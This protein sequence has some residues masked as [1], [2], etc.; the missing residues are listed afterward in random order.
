MEAVIKYRI[1]FWGSGPWKGLAVRVT[2]FMLL[3]L[4][5]SASAFDLKILHIND[6]H[7]HLQ[8]DSKMELHLGG[9][10]TRVQA[11]GFPRL[12]TL[13][14]KLSA[15]QTNVL[16]LHA[17]DAIT[18]DL[19]YTLFKGE[20][21][22]ALMN[23]ICFDAF[24]LGNHEFD[25]GDSGLARFLDF[26][27]RGDC[28]TAVLGAN[29]V[30]EVGVSPLAKSS[31]TDY[32]RPYVVKKVGGV[33]VGIVGID[34]AQKTKLSSNPDETTVFLDEAQTAQEMIDELERQGIMHIILMTHYQYLNDLALVPR[35]RGVDVVVGGDS[36]TLLGDFQDIELNS[37]GP[38]PTVIKDAQGDTV[39][40]VQAW[41]YS[42]IVGELNVRFADDGTVVSCSGTPHLP[43][44]DSFR[45]T[46]ADDAWVELEGAERDGVETAI[47]GKPELSIVEEDVNTAALLASFS[48]EVN[49]LKNQVIGNAKDRLC[50]ERIPG[51][52]KS[53][54][55]D[56]SE[57]AAHG[58]DIATL[59]AHVFR[60]ASKTS[61]IAI[62]NAG[63]VRTD[64][65]QGEFTIA[66]AYTLLPFANT[67]MELRM[68]GLEVHS[69][70]EDALDYALSKGGSSGAYPYAA[71][72]RWEVNINAPKGHRFSH[73]QVKGKHESQWAALDF[74]KI[75]TVVTNSY[76]SEGRDGYATFKTVT[77]AGRSLNTYLDYAQVFVDYVKDRGTFG[78][79]PASEYSTR[80]I[81]Q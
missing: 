22:A 53:K 29:V 52:G 18:G 33:N 49:Q 61:D 60:R 38:Y 1:V 27:G 7:S 45:R 58:S 16:K 41:Q 43:L 14:D 28:D 39:C 30:P 66:D 64:V 9:E 8:S 12:A 36:H 21:D 5:T 47:A 63:G 31:A 56:A 42:A 40:V 70:L 79:L 46:N 37:R 78:K 68:T 11:G 57:T 20:A 4:T 15:E 81:I 76:I 55:C 23:E 19:F 69:V 73:I 6:H 71:G 17:G 2:A 26:L 10:A 74:D 62:Q 35:L 3:W 59:V 75:F 13:F 34:I 80:S 65:N 25:D 48:S 72:L 44:A 50:L 54:L 32:I 77:D 51:Q 24:V 67:L